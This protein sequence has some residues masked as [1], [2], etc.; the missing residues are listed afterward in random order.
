[1]HI[2]LTFGILSIIYIFVY[3]EIGKTYLQQNY[4]Q[5]KFKDFR[6]CNKSLTYTMYDIYTKFITQHGCFIL[7]ENHQKIK[8]D[9]TIISKVYQTSA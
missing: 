6:K 2:R 7:Q 4:V 5:L 9:E 8:I 3:S 1:M